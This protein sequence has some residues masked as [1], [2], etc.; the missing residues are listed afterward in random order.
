MKGILKK[1]AGAFVE[2]DETPVKKPAVPSSTQTVTA[3]VLRLHNEG[4][5]EYTQYR[6]KFSKI[7]ADENQRN[8]PGNDYFEFVVMKNA[9]SAIPQE[10]VKYQAAFAGWA[11]GG[12]QTKKSLLDTAQIYLG[13]VDREI[14]EFGEAYQ[15]QYS[16]QVTANEELI[17]RKS[18]EVQKLVLKINTLNTEIANLKKENIDST[19]KLTAKHDAFMAAGTAQRQEILDEIDKIQNFIN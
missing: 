15:H 16:S 10:E 2:I 12:N 4:S 8:Y 13:L 14:K 3:P 18:E 6:E 11:V 1:V 19:A 17:A 9:M 7:L 5:P